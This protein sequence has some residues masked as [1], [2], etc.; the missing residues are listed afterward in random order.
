M[1][2]AGVAQQKQQ[3]GFQL[4]SLAKN[5]LISGVGVSCGT[6][7]TNPIGEQQGR[8]AAGAVSLQHACVTAA[9]EVLQRQ[10]ELQVR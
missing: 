6:T 5:I 9:V 2:G 1:G 3:Q 10:Q 8:L 4:P 7:V